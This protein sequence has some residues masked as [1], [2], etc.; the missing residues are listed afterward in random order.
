LA[1]RIVSTILSDPDLRQRLL[2]GLAADDPWMDVH[3]AAR[4]L[5]LTPKAL[6]KIA[7]ERHEIPYEQDGPRCKMW[8][9]RS[10]LDAYRAGHRF[11]VGN[12]AA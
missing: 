3:A 10:A 11:R 9:R 7:G 2:D 12:A 1:E 6:R 4:H 8:F 5:G